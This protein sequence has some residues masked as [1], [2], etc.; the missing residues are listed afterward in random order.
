M[1]LHPISRRSFV[2]ATLVL[3]ACLFVGSDVSATYGGLYA[4]E[5]LTTAGLMLQVALIYRRESEFLWR[6][7]W[8]FWYALGIGAITYLFVSSA[9]VPSPAPFE[10]EALLRTEH[11]I[12]RHYAIFLVGLVPVLVSCSRTQPR[13]A[14]RQSVG[15]AMVTRIL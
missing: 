8:R 1:T 6:W 14:K 10:A 7:R 3:T 13:S 2:L 12:L 11:V 4:A 5:Y 9:Y 15:S